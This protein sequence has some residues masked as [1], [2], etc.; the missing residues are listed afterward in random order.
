MSMMTGMH[1]VSGEPNLHQSQQ[2]KQQQG[3][4]PAMAFL[5]SGGSNGGVSREGLEVEM[6]SFA[7]YILG[8]SREKTS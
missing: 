8:F 3:T 2:A 1:P 4:S 5:G 7:P 6:A